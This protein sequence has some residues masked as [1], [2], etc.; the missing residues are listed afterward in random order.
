MQV[1]G[2]PETYECRTASNAVR[3]HAFVTMK[4]RIL[5][6]YAYRILHN[7]VKS[8]HT[9]VLRLIFVYCLLL[10]P[11]NILRGVFAQT[12]QKSRDIQHQNMMKSH[13]VCIFVL[14]EPDLLTF[15]HE[16]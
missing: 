6:S 4:E 10:F 14:D 13:F 5:N 11:C 7:G 8:K 16:R 1:Q 15:G 9:K 12:A 2:N 3:V